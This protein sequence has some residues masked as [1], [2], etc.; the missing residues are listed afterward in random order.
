[1]ARQPRTNG[2]WWV[3]TPMSLINDIPTRAELVAR[4]VS[5]ADKRINRLGAMITTANGRLAN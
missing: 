4:I 2:N 5:E 1:M 3:S